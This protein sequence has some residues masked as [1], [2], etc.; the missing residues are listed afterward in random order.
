MQGS[1]GSIL[2]CSSVVRL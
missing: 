1:I 2:A